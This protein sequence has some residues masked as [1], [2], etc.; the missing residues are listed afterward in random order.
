M[1][2]LKIGLFGFGCV[3]QGLY[4]TLQHSTGFKTRIEKI[5][6][7]NREKPRP[8]GQE[9]FSYDKDDILENS[10]INVVV[11]LIDDADEAFKIV[12]TALKNGKN[13]V[14]ANKK[15][16]ALHL[17]TLLRLAKENAVSLLYEA[18]A[19][20]SIPIIRTLEEY[21]DNEE[22][23]KLSGIFN[24]TTNYI[25]TKLA[26]ENL[27]FS[28]ALKKAQ[29]LGFA[30]SNPEADVEAF[31]PLYKSVILALHGFGIILDPAQ[32]SRF[33]ITTLKKG[34]LD[35]ASKNNYKIKLVPTIQR[36][37]ENKLTAYVIPKFIP[38]DHQLAKVDNEFNGVIVEGQ[39]SG[40]QFF[41]GRGA[42]SLPT[43]A[44]VLSDISS[45]SFSY[46]YE[47]KKLG[48]EKSIQFSD[49][50][51]ISLYVSSNKI[52]D[53]EMFS[54]EEIFED[55]KKNAFYYRSGSIGL[56]ELKQ[57]EPLIRKKKIFVAEM[58][59]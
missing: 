53:F 32:I 23:S 21:F 10:N 35:F 16:L 1:K 30:E 4:H 27:E 42:G 52:S 11:E 45:L 33:G 44:A 43:G 37:A 58:L 12:S 49:D 8:I 13:V 51:R 5:V 48:Q 50:F 59:A 26:T 14:T 9:F 2:T 7:K 39:F 28:E 3:G 6:V 41:V 15:M 22:L 24:G 25:L 17:E 40:E 38:K 29:E 54:F 36:L 55:F 18:A 19:C 46:A 31:D 20:G 34:D 56:A 47:N 57:L